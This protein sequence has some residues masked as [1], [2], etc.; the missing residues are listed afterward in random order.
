MKVSPYK[1]IDAMFFMIIGSWLSNL[2]W[3]IR[4]S[5]DILRR[6]MLMFMQENN[7][8]FLDW[9]VLMALFIAIITGVWVYSIKLRKIEDAKSTKNET[10]N[11]Q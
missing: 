2:C 4:F 7:G 9:F 10:E 6:E 1:I 5:Q 8:Y 3:H 11:K